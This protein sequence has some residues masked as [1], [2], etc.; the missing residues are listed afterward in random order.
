MEVSGK[1]DEEEGVFRRYRVNSSEM[2]SE[3][4]RELNVARE[5]LLPALPLKLE[6]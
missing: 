6:T 5:V 2:H 3:E 4:E 1:K